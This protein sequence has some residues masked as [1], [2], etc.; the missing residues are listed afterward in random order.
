MRSYAIA[1]GLGLV[2]SGLTGTAP[3]LAQAAEQTSGAAA[4]SARAVPG[5]I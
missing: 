1:L 2:L 5:A 3:V 4:R